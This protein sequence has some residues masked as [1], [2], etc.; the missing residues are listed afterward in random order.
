MCIN[1]FER[2]SF[3]NKQVYCCSLTQIGLFFFLYT[4]LILLASIWL[5]FHFGP[6]LAFSILDFSSF[7]IFSSLKKN[8]LS[9]EPTLPYTLLSNCNLKK[10][11]AV[12]STFKFI[13]KNQ[14]KVKPI[15]TH[16]FGQSTTCRKAQQRPHRCR[17]VFFSV[18]FRKSYNT[19]ALRD[20]TATLKW[21]D[22]L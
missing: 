14:T 18:Q 13:G 5:W 20:N 6:F 4:Q 19:H 1:T 11:W 16:T 7:W 2:L 9:S 22:Y 17:Y 15:P 3:F 8:N 21:D 12:C 10:L